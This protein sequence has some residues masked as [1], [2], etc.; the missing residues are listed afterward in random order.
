[1]NSH[2]VRAPLARMLGLI[3]IIDQEDEADDRE[4]LHRQLKEASQELDAVVK[5]MNRLLEKE[6]FTSRK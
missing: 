3:Y 5:S 2:E 6:I 4:D 1:M